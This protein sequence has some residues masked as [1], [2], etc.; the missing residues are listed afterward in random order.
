MHI[1]RSAVAFAAVVAVG[2]GLASPAPASS[3]GRGVERSGTCS[4]STHWYL[5][6]ELSRGRLKAEARLE[7]GVRGQ[8]WSWRILHNGGVSARGNATTGTR[9]WYEIERSLI[10]ASGPDRIV[11]KSHNAVTGEQCNGSLRI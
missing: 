11:F 4:R 5:E 8:H 10:D 3:K 6:A 2:I 7:S 1:R 9:G